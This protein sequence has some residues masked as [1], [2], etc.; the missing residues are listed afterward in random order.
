MCYGEV[1]DIRNQGSWTAYSCPT[2]LRNIACGIMGRYTRGDCT[3]S[4][5]T[6]SNS[7][8]Y[9]ILYGSDGETYTPPVGDSVFYNFAITW[10]KDVVDDTL[11]T[12]YG[13]TIP[14]YLKTH[15]KSTA[16]KPVSEGRIRSL[17]I[18]DASYYDGNCKDDIDEIKAVNETCRQNTVVKY[19]ECCAEIGICDV[20]WMGCI[21][22]MCSC[23][24]PDS[25]NDFT[26]QDCL[27]AII[28]ESMN[29]TCSLDRLYPTAT[30]TAAPTGSPTAESERVILPFGESTEEFVMYMAIFVIVFVLIAIAAFWYYRKKT[31]KGVHSFEETEE[32]S[33][34]APKVATSGYNKT[35]THAAV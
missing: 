3:R 31:A 15:E 29:T 18:E 24:D 11:E 1:I 22:D 9:N 26:E 28:H 34:M 21:E 10:A 6:D 35:E 20:L 25:N 19:S 5:M 8:C 33:E 23:T 14:D 17:E 16:I 32:E 13:F 30:P 27:D 12:T 7:A 4:D 2:C